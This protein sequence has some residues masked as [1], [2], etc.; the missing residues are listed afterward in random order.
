MHFAPPIA[1][2]SYKAASAAKISVVKMT[3]IKPDAGWAMYRSK[4]FLVGEEG[5][6]AERMPSRKVSGGVLAREHAKRNY[7]K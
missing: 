6:T 2:T 7:K 5:F 4:R 3:C 1:A